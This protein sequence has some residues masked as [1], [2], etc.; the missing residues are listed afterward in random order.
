MAVGKLSQR[1]VRRFFPVMVAWQSRLR[2]R[3]FEYVSDAPWHF[4]KRRMQAH[5]GSARTWVGLVIFGLLAGLVGPFGTFA[6][7]PILMRVSYWLIIT[8]G[9]YAIGFFFSVLL[10]SWLGGR[11]SW[12]VLILVGLLAGLPSALFAFTL[13]VLVFGGDSTQWTE[14][15]G[16]FG[17]CAIIAIGIS[18]AR[19]VVMPR[20]A[21]ISASG[22]PAA[23]PP[24][25]PALL[26][27]LPH[28]L[29]GRLLHLAVADH[30]VEVTTDKGHE[31][32]LMRLSD[33]IRETA[34]VHGLQVHRS[35]WVALAA[36]RRATRQAGKPA[37]EL[38]NGTI[39]PVSRTY[40]DA[41]R[42]AGLLSR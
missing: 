25:P 22:S 41:A 18:A 28:P 37:L 12:Q 29:R 21:P 40:A 8:I 11:P 4:T 36:V 2:R 15:P 27:R 32:V 35:H 42:A 26:E 14:L 31:L 7:M 24:Q 39:V 6:S 17:Y 13:N 30:Y 3:N 10:K 1:L 9:S 38:E 33:A 5:F 34:P 16:L 20:P 23:V 19:L